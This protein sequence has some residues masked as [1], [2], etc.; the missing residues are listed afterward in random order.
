MERF[1][2]GLPV[3]SDDKIEIPPMPGRTTTSTTPIPYDTAAPAAG[4]AKPPMPAA[5]KAGA[6]AKPLGDKNSYR[7]WRM[8]D[9]RMVY[10]KPG[11]DPPAGAQQVK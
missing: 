8:P 2:N 3:G 11:E 6:G 5:P 4:A 10:T 1:R 7:S 9:G